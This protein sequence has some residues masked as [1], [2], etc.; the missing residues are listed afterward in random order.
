M[1]TDDRSTA[2]ITV[3][4]SIGTALLTSLFAQYLLEVMKDRQLNRQHE[5]ERHERV[6]SAQFDIVENMTAILW[7]PGLSRIDSQPL[8]A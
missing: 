8:A 2:L 4:V 3:L 5:S 1:A 6:V 7:N